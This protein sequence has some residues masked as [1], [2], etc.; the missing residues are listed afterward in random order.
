MNMDFEELIT[1]S[2]SAKAQIVAGMLKN[3]GLDVVV[4]NSPFNAVIPSPN[5]WGGYTLYVK[6]N[7]V[8][9]AGKLL[10]EFDDLD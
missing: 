9:A 6:K 7:Q 1:L 4:M 8:E 2:D 10:E 3:H 5:V